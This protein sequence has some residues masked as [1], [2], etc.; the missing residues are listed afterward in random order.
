MKFIVSLLLTVFINLSHNDYIVID[1]IEFKVVKKG[2]SDRKYI[3]LHGDEQT[4]RMALEYH[5][6]KYGGTGFFINNNLRDVSF[7]GGLIDPNRI[8]SSYGAK[9]NIHKYNPQWAPKKKQEVLDAIDKDRPSFLNAIFPSN[10]GLLIALHNNYKGYN[11]YKEVPISD[12]TSIKKT[13]MAPNLSSK[14]NKTNEKNN[15]Q[16]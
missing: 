1:T 8:F 15:R 2:K 3:W 4:A 6:N 7:Y 12:S 16:T 5:L 11:I 13:V 14:S 9:K 10:G